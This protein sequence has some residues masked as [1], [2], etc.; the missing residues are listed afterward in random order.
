MSKVTAFITPKDLVWRYISEKLEE[1]KLCIEIKCEYDSDDVQTIRIYTFEPN[2]N[3][4][5]NKNKIEKILKEW[6]LNFD[7]TE[8]SCDGSGDLYYTLYKPEKNIE[9]IMEIDAIKDKNTIDYS[10]ETGVLLAQ[11]NL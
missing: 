11:L 3:E 4:E 5:I 10:H 9:K 6:G 8:E 1:G 7:S 2:E